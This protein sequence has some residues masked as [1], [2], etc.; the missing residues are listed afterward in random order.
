MNQPY[1]EVE[2]INMSES[3]LGILP[4]LEFKYFDVSCHEANTTQTN[5]V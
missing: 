4:E 1:V 5:A 2:P 3:H